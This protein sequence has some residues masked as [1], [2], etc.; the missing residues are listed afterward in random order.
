MSSDLKYMA[1]TTYVI[2]PEI[3]PS[4]RIRQKKGG[5]LGGNRTHNL[6]CNPSLRSAE[7]A[8]DPFFPGLGVA[9]EGQQT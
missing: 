1:P 6:P 8:I 4:Y 5:T 9:E 7:P 2:L 3:V